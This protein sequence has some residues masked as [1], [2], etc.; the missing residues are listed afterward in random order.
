[1]QFTKSLLLVLAL[2][3]GGLSGQVLAGE[4]DP[5]FIGLSQDSANRVSHVLHFA[6]LQL[7]RGHPVTLWLNEGG[8]SWPRKNTRKNTQTIRRHSPN[9]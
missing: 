6:D 9:W 4:K 8:S 7:K 2:I 1:M 5:L 3:T